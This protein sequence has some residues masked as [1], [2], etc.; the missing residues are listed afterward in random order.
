MSAK[1]GHNYERFN[2]L[3]EWHSHPNAPAVPSPRDSLTIREILDHPET[4][5]NFLVLLIVRLTRTEVLEMSAHAFLASGQILE[6]EIEIQETTI[7][8]DLS[9]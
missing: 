5:A 6:C 7:E 2:Y 4:D 1:H 8:R 3:G 9:S